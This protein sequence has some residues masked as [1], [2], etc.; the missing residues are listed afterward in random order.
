M[1]KI[2]TNSNTILKRVFYGCRKDIWELKGRLRILLKQLDMPLA[3][4]G[5]LVLAC[6]YLHNLCRILHD[7]FNKKWTESQ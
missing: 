3:H 7:Q 6:I 5:Y 4:V 2:N 1:L